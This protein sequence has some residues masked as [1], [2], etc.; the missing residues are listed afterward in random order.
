MRALCW[1][2]VNDLAVETVPDPVLVNPHDVIV[3]VRLTTTCGSDL[4]F[5]DGYLPGMREGDVIGHE[6]MGEVVETG[7]E[8]RSAKAG[9]R[10]VVPSFIGCGSCWYCGNGL[11]ST[12]DTT[13]PNAALQQP[14]L[15]YPSGGIY[16]YTH[17]FGGYQGS[18]AEYI[19]V[20]F[21]DVNCF[22]VPAGVT[23]EQALFCSDA[24]PTGLMGA[25][26]C[27]IS[28][29]DTVAVWGSGGVGLM[30]AH[31]ARLLGAERVIVIDRFPNRLELARSRAGA[32]TIDYTAVDSVAEALRET[33]GGRGPDACI[34][35]V[36]MEGHGTGLQQLYDKAKQLL[37]LETDRATSLREAILAC[38]KAGV[39]SVLGVYGLTDKF[40]MGV[41]TN[42]GLTIR[43]AQQRGQAYMPRMFDYIEQGDLDPSYLITH[44]LP[45][46]EAVRGYD[47]FKN[48]KQECVRAVF[49]P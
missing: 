14:L 21:G 1:N 22:S 6:F 2:G 4:H 36:G 27:D 13:N 24:V 31:T 38:R 41:V 17:P 18:H 35:A 16:G 26:F 28:P 8:V 43:S 33:T 39:V 29:G 44:D 23:D 25:D 42:K 7:P 30:A 11:Y 15:G 12:C 20:P 40:P 9:D 47:L 48:S 46:T 45:L 5:I 3:R 49:R 10:V 37:R 34:D 19:R 32:E